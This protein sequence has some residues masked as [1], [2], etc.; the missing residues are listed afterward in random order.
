MPRHS[1]AMAGWCEDFMYY[2][3]ILQ[4]IGAAGKI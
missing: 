3:Y 4:S 1:V 2:V